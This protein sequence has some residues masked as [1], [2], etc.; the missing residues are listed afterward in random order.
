MPYTFIKGQILADLVAAFVE[1]PL[2]QEIERQDM[3]GKSI[4]MVTLKEPLSWKLYVDGAANQRGS[5]VGLVLISPEKTTIEKSLILGFSVTNNETEYEA[6]LVGMTMVQ[7]MGEKAVKIFSG[8]KLMV[9][10]VKGELKARDVR[11][12]GYL[13]QVRHLRSGFESFNLLQISRSGNTYTNSLATFATS[14]AQN[15]PRVILIE[16]LCKPTKMKKE[17]V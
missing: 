3:D 9:G 5:G 8:S 12:Q 6:L 7:K 13:S 14:S 1:S 15:L 16:D 10:Q 2:E 11:M 17:M 4:S